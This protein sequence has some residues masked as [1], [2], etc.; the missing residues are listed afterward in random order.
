M[1]YRNA[2]KSKKISQLLAI[3]S[4]RSQMNP[5]FIFNALNSVNQFI[6]KNDER[7]ANK[8][9]AEFSK[10]MRLV[11]DSS[12]EDFIPLAQEKDM[13]SLYLKLEH[14]RFRDKFDYELHIDENLDLEV[15]EIP[16]MLLQP[17][18]ENA[19]WHGLRC[20]ET[21]GMLYVDISEKD[22]NI[23]ATISDNGIGEDTI[24]NSQKPKIRRACKNQKDSK[25][26]C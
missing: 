3:K 7:A 6:A 14:L 23:W 11:L 18:I 10:L 9:L 22:N 26:Q 1:I 20:K 25:Y 13:L 24:K 21:E 5:H 8:F 2:K 17:Y 15:I 12:Q 19:I 16:P 4:L